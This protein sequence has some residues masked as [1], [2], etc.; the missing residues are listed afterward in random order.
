VAP[1]QIYQARKQRMQNYLNTSIPTIDKYERVL[2]SELFS[3]MEGFSDSF[4]SKNALPLSDYSRKVVRDPLHQWSRQWEYPYVYNQIYAYLSMAGTNSTRVLDAGSGITFFPYF[5]KEQ[6]KHIDVY[7]CD[8]DLSLHHIFQ[9]INSY[10]KDAVI[11]HDADLRSTKFDNDYFDIVYCISVLEHTDQY[12]LIIDELNRIMKPNGR[13]IVTFDISL[14]GRGDISLEASKRL[15]NA[16]SAAFEID[17]SIDSDIDA[18][19]AKPD[20]LTT[21][22]VTKDLLPWRFPSLA[23]RIKSMIRAGGSTS[24]PPVYTVYC[25]SLTKK[26]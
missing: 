6:Y 13:L 8:Y 2:A 22:R 16:L 1:N 10:Y 14:D 23:S 11:F 20:I 3:I 12:E 7:C 26:A 5:I 18:M 17:G 25:L 9:L 4:I 19:V 21:T 24:W 15:I